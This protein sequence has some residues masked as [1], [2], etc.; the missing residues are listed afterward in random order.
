[1][2]NT[3]SA[4][5]GGA[6]ALLGA[7]GASAQ[8]S[9][10]LFQIGGVDV[11]PHLAYSLVYDDNIFLEHKAKQ[12]GGRGNP[13]RDHDFIHKITPGLLLKAGDANSRQS[14]Y[15]QANYDAIISK[16]TD[17]RG[18][19]ALDHNGSVEL[20]GKL[21]RL[22]LSLNQSL[23]SSSDADQ[24][25]LA[26]NGRVKQKTW[27]TK[28]SAE[29]EVSEKTTATL[30]LAQSIG[31]YSAPL[32]DSVDRSA[33]I[34]LDYQVLPKVK[35][36]VGGGAGY[37]QIDGTAAGHNPNSV[38][39]NG[40][41][42]LDWQATEKVSIKVNGGVESR[43]IQQAGVKDPVNLI[44]G[45]NADWKADERTTVTIGANRGLKGSNSQGNTINEE[46]SLTAGVKHGLLENVN[47]TLDGGYSFSHYKATALAGVPASALRNDNY[48]FVK[49]GVAYR[50]AERA[51]A[52]VFYQYRRNDANLAANANDFYNNQ[53]GV[54]L[55]YRF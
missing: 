24:R 23:T 33:L 9:A 37:L 45:L 10:P 51:Q 39:E 3:K 55:S 4:V 35:M 8:D 49:P 41:V 14:A 27:S 12:G 25:T 54:E 38:Y 17:Y 1:M 22:S 50:F 40:Q 6:V 5:I 30:D 47:L 26:A 28:A 48:F 32:V 52:S 34:W 46:T 7:A 31:D 44:F 13:G 29:Y 18:A 36:G 21:N 53:L 19:D 42:R 16:F 15:F 11:R 43:N 2:K 20:G